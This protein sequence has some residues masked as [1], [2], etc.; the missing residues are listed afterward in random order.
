MFQYPFINHGYVALMLVAGNIAFNKGTYSN[1]NKARGGRDSSL[2]VDGIMVGN[3]RD[4]CAYVRVHRDIGEKAYW[5]VDLGGTYVIYNL[6]L[7]GRGD[8]H[9]SKCMES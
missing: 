6:T 7:Y 8:R 4:I 3:P 1:T 9:S 2:A 5:T